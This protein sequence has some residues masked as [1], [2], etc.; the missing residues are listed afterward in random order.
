MLV[1]GGTHN[2]PEL[3]IRAL[4]N[5]KRERS[6]SQSSWGVRLDWCEE[7]ILV[8]GQDHI[9]MSQIEKGVESI[10]HRGIDQRSEYIK[11]DENQVSH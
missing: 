6:R 8:S 1:V 10:I 3:G 5:E 7:G 4:E 2:F 11:A 9:R